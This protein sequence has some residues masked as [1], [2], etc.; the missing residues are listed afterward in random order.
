MSNITAALGVAQLKKVDKIIKMRRKNAEY[1]TK[2]LSAVNEVI[3][4]QSLRGYFHVYQMYTI[5]LKKGNRDGLSKHL[6]R[7]GITTKVSFHPAHLTHFYRKKLGYN[8]R[9]PVTEEISKQVL[10][11]PMYPSLARGEM[12]YIARAVETFFR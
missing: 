9:L 12:D 4:P 6:T 7:R 8:I 3:P 1:L 11:L 2:K 5:R 10:T